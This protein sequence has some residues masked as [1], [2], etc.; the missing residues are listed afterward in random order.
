MSAISEAAFEK[1]MEAANA[2]VEEKGFFRRWH[3]ADPTKSFGEL[4][5]YLAKTRPAPAPAPAPAFGPHGYKLYPCARVCGNVLELGGVCQD[6]NRA[7]EACAAFKALPRC[8]FC[9]GHKDS[10]DAR[11]NTCDPSVLANKLRPPPSPEGVYECYICQKEGPEPACEPCRQAMDAFGAVQCVQ[12]D[13]YWL[14]AFG[15]DWESPCGQCHPAYRAAYAARAAPA[16][17]AAAAAPAAAAQESDDE[18][19]G[20]YNEKKKEWEAYA[21]ELEAAEEEDGEEEDYD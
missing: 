8:V 12:C 1:Q 2:G 10:A 13:A 4:R 19:M 5:A 20:W 15:G 9:K 14:G 6:C 11:C 17:A 21:D 3:R 7:D 16:A 18:D